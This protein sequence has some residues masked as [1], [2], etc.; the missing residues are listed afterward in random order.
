[1]SSRELK[2]FTSDLLS[3]SSE[4]ATKSLQLQ[5]ETARKVLELTRDV[6]TLAEAA[7][8]ASKVS[9]QLSDILRLISDY[10]TTLGTVHSLTQ[11]VEA[12]ATRSQGMLHILLKI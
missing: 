5:L 3:R 11:G 1:M 2:Y 6:G 8:E 7:R 9:D 10:N 4:D 12:L